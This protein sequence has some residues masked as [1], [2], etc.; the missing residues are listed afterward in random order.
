MA[1]ERVKVLVVDDHQMFA[2][3]LVR[4]L[5]DEP[6]LDVVGVAT[7][8]ADAR[9]AMARQRPDVVLLDH[10][11]PDGHGVTAVE[12]LRAAAPTAQLVLLTG[13]PDDAVLS[14][15]LAAG[16]SFVTKDMASGELVRAIRAAHDGET[17]VS[18]TVRSSRPADAT[19]L[20][21]ASLT[22]RELD[23]LRL[24][25]EGLTNAAIADRLSLSV[26]TVR[27]HVQNAMTKLGAHSKLEATAI[28]VRT[29]IV[30]PPHDRA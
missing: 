12:E 3:S 5:G 14:N 15:A 26:N 17:F 9:R 6:D 4:L 21:R 13:D 7:N 2:E 28:A 30:A 8:L 27:N 25:V 24:A 1:Q 23:V 18:A 20:D 11:L 19:T 22:P 29:G 16:C 10:H